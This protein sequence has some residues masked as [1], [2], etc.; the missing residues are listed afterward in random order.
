MKEY[1][2]LLNEI[3]DS[4]T[5]R[6]DEKVKLFT[7]AELK[8]KEIF[9]DFKKDLNI[10]MLCIKNSVQEKNLNEIIVEIDSLSRFYNNSEINE[11]VSQQLKEL[12]EKVNNFLTRKP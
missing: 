4:I 6:I 3:L 9:I 1:T 2:D 12:K 5:S 7:V 8:K 10:L 11:F